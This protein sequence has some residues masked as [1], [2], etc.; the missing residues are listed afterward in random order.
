MLGLV[1]YFVLYPKEEVPLQENVVVNDVAVDFP[2]LFEQR[3]DLL[4]EERENH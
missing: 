1:G 4:F 3:D 2:V